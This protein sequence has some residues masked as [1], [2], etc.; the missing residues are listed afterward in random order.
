MTASEG[1]R[2]R[3]SHITERRAVE[4]DCARRDGQSYDA[5][6]PRAVEI[7]CGGVPRRIHTRRTRA[8]DGGAAP[9]AENT[10]RRQFGIRQ[11]RTVDLRSVS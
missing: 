7:G 8:G 11:L 4:C 1:L 6:G 3:R 10:K 9:T 2:G 5:L